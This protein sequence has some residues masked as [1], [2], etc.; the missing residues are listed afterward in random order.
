MSELEKQSHPIPVPERRTHAHS[1]LD[2]SDRRKHRR[3]TSSFPV[4]IF[5]GEGKN[6]KTYSARA[7]DIS[8]GGMCLE[9][10]DIPLDDARVRVNFEI[11]D[12]ALPEEFEQGEYVFDVDVRRL[13]RE[14]HM[15]GVQF[16]EPVSINLAR[17]RWK[18]LR[19]TATLGMLLTMALIVFVKMENVYYF[20]FD[21]PVFLYSL[22][23]SGYLVTR[24]LFAAFYHPPHPIPDGQEP[25]VTVI[26]PVKN[27]EGC[28]ART[29][30]CALD[31]KYPPGKVQV[32]AVNDGSTDGT[33]AAMNA[34]RE[35]YPELVVVS[36]GESR[37]K[38]AALATGARLATGEILVFTDSDS[39]M[40]PDAIRH[41]VD[42]F[43][44]PQVMAVTGHCD[45]ENLWTNT[46]TKM[47]AVRY[48]ISFRIMKAAESIFDL[49]TCLSG[50]LAAYRRTMFLEVMDE[51]LA[52]KF[53]G[54]P[55]TFG[56]DR[57]LTNAVLKRGFRVLYDSR[58]KT[59]TIVPDSYG[60]FWKQQM[61][62]KRS[63][64]RETLAACR[65][66]WKKPPFASLSFYLGL[67][68]PLLG[69]LV[70][71]RA[72]IW[73]PITQR[74]SPVSYIAGILLM[75]C[76]M[77]TAYLWTKRSRLWIYGIPF[78]FYYMFLL[79]W[80][81]PYAIVTCWKSEWGTRK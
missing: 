75:S 69:P 67:M 54:T 29:L 45:V 21:V 4:T 23:V 3:Y 1:R 62:W 25:T 80:Q 61:R 48:F 76:M 72:L 17:T 59:R 38:R 39:F 16:K 49:V 64:F 11:P 41:L 13:D 60:V 32:I 81:L 74:V 2:A 10:V 68:L 56:D 19:Q 8:D 36:L 35:D 50:P 12:G 31:Q 70:V 51:W 18:Q 79:V 7:R 78:C 66:M 71:F 53:L 43:A 6:A 20:W 24:F 22:L 52:Q 47:Q 9:N 37:G 27:E 34:V 73:V 5:V 42:G 15:A 40:E 57:A 28:I 46:L 33:L 55:A 65:F 58:A 77:C 26:V 63:W 14:H 44:D 30:E